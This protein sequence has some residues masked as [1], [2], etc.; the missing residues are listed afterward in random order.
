MIF[1]LWLQLA[2]PNP[3]QKQP[4]DISST[5]ILHYSGKVLHLNAVLWLV[6]CTF[7]KLMKKKPVLCWYSVLLYCAVLI[8]SRAPSSAAEKGPEVPGVGSL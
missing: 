3:S 1:S 5:D 7:T 4:N 8:V 6:C 2:L